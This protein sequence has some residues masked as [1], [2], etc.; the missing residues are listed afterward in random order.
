MLQHFDWT[1]INL[2]PVIWNSLFLCSLT[3]CFFKIGRMC[4]WGLLLHLPVCNVDQLK[5]DPFFI[6]CIITFV[7]ELKMHTTKSNIKREHE[8]DANKAQNSICYLPL[9]FFMSIWRFSISISLSNLF[10]ESRMSNE[11]HSP[12]YMTA[13]S[14]PNRSTKGN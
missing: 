2:L 7:Y 11:H 13:I 9:S 4:I 6:W 10:I 14:I 3:L 1:I 12:R 5:W 8:S